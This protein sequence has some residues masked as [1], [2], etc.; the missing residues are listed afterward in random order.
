MHYKFSMG[1]SYL[2]FAILFLTF[3]VLR[4]KHIIGGEIYYSCLS[5][6]L[7][8]N[9]ATYEFTLKI[10]RDCI[11]QGA[12]LDDP[13]KLGIYEKLSN[14]NFRFVNS[15][16]V[17]LISS[18]R[19]ASE[20]P[21]IITPPSV[22]VEEGIYEF[23]ATLPIIQNTYTIAYQR[24]C[25]NETI[26][27]II[28]PGDQG[29][30]YTIDISPEAQKICNN[31]P[32]FKS[33]PPIII[34]E[35][36]PLNYD[37]SAIDQEGDIITYEFC[38]P[39]SA[40]GKQGSAEGRPGGRPEDCDGVTPNPNACPPPFTLVQFRAPFFTALNPLGGNPQ[41]SIDPLTGLITG[42]PNTLG[43]FVVG[44]CIKEY[45]NGVL[46]STV[47][48]DFQFNVITCENTLNARMQSDSVQ[49]ND[50]YILN[51][52]GDLTVNLINQSTIESNIK[53]YDWEFL[54]NG[55]TQ[56]INTKNASVTFPGLGSYSGKLIL[57]KGALDCTDSADIT[58]NILPDIHADFRYNYDTCIAG[59]VRFTDLSTTGSGQLTD[60]IWTL[61][62]NKSVFLQNHDYIFNTPGIKSPKLVVR[63]ISGCKDSIIKDFSYYPVPPLLIINP[64][65][66][67]GCNPLSVFFENLSVPIDESY[68]ILWDFGDGKTS[69][70]ISP[71]HT[72]KDPGTYSIKLEITSPIGCYTMASYPNWINVIESPVAG[73][74]YNP[75]SLSSFQK[76]VNLTDQ[77]KSAEFLKYLI[78]DRFILF[79]R[80][81]QYT[82]KDTGVQK[83]SQIVSRPNGC[84]DTLTIFIDVEPKVTYFLPNA[85]T[86]NGDG[87]NEEFVGVGYVEGLQDFQMSIW[88]RW[89]SQ[90]FNS[91][92]PLT[93][94]NGRVNGSGDFVPPGV[95]VYVIQYREPRGKIVYLK[96]FATVVR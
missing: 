92:D 86:P 82:F 74:D 32:R 34:C 37:H 28:N 48:R 53:T 57:N 19:L 81:A 11:S 65:T 77:S 69:K 95:Y 46:L 72:F 12:I 61:E 76:Q 43:Q 3:G 70:E 73:F 96:G 63:D 2:I 94:W 84:T 52:C 51:S 89:G 15:Y 35:G 41:V 14:S 71:N 58:I 83:I 40:G 44:V 6:N 59:A 20:N 93:G 68:D 27:N 31:S 29:A 79:D 60:W 26:S 49:T 18:R 66:F 80:N 91:S 62:Q 36:R 25:R 85:F 22:C 8:N 13:A 23:T 10:Y 30:A 67:T 50:R 24:C 16:S 38:A 9:T 78:N 47:R 88:D 55:K 90:L 75:K 87:K 4:A 64:N 21:C 39:S 17:P 5:V 56:V 45:R 54:I 1:R 33:F 7:A 42:T